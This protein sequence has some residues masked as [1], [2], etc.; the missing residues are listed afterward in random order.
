MD[1]IKRNEVLQV[2]SVSYP[3]DITVR[4]SDWL[5]AV[6]C[7]M[8]ASGLV[9][10]VF[11]HMAPPGKRAFHYFSVAILFTASV[12][13][14]AMASNLGKTGVLVEFNRQRSDLYQGP[15][16]DAYRSI[17]YARYID[18]TVTTPLLLLDLLLTTGLP[19]SEIFFTIFMD[20]VMIETGLIGALVQ[21]R[22][23]FGFFAFGCVAML[24]VFWILIGP[25]R[26]A[27]R[28]L[29]QDS[30]KSY[31]VS[32]SILCFL[33]FLYPIAWGLADGGNVITPDGEMIFY[34]VLDVLAKPGFIAFHLF[35]LRNIEYERY[36]LQSG[37]YSV[38]AVDNNL[39]RHENTFEKGSRH[40]RASI[41]TQETAVNNTTPPQSTAA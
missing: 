7:I 13:Y 3:I 2:N 16:A 29:G 20:L 6:F 9:L 5:W 11:T 14:F 39:V 21:S 30:H 8:A 15:A 35:S 23:K 32:A 17:W 31:I 25:A 38:G 26:S 10:T 40:P 12:A 41:A 4:G 1:L 34:G 37:H 24:Y 36:Q 28:A 33:W 19:T 27:A 18:W 22:Y